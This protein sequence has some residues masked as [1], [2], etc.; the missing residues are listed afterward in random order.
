MLHEA[1]DLGLSVGWYAGNEWIV[2]K[3]D[4]AIV[5]E[6]KIVGEEPVTDTNLASRDLTNSCV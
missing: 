1:L 5:R 2:P 6:A 3:V 4:A